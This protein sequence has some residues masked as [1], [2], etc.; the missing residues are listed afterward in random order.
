M[1]RKMMT[2]TVTLVKSNG[3][4]FENIKANVQREKIFIDDAKLPIEEGDRIIRELSNGLSE[5]FLILDRG[6]YDRTHGIPAHYQMKVKKESAIDLERQ[7]TMQFHIGTVYGSNIGTQ[8]SA[9]VEN[10][11]NFEKVDQLIEEHGGP[12]KEELRAMIEE[13]KE[14]FDDSEKVKKGSLSKFSEL[15]E[16]HSWISGT[17]AQMGLGFLTGSLFK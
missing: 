14:F 11:F 12:D 6:Y 3:E 16:R 2:D 8:G 13:L 10:V 1:L 15:M 17:V 5:S 4:K 9:H 7:T